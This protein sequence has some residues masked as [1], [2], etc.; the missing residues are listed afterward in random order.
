MAQR[1]PQPWRGTISDY[2]FRALIARPG[3]T[4]KPSKLFPILAKPIRQDFLQSLRPPI[5]IP[6]CPAWF[7]RGFQI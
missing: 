2:G 6:R 4:L 1:N 5:V 3:P 7:L